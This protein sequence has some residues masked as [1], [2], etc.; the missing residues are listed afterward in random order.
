MYIPKVYGQSK[1]SGCIFCGKQSIRMNAQGIPVCVAH[2][3]SVLNDFKCACGCWLDQR[4]G[5]W[6]PYWLCQDCGIVSIRKALEFNE[7]K[8]ISKQTAPPTHDALHTPAA[9][10][11]ESSS[12]HPLQEKRQTKPSPSMIGYASPD[13]FK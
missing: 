5:K 7:I 10:H 13:S 11:N 6:G 8:D 1:N 12:A 9:S 3:D 4:E 2:K